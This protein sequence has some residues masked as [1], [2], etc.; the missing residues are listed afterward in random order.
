ML[1]RSTVPESND[2]GSWMGVKLELV[3]PV[4]DA[5]LYTKAKGFRDAVQA[6]ILKE[7]A[8]VD[9]Y[10]DRGDEAF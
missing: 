3:G 2:K 10:A 6:G 5:A 7:A 4:T 1:F 8:P 9:E